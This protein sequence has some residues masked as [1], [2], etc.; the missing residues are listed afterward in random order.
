MKHA[1]FSLVIACV[2][3]FGPFIASADV[4]VR[5]VRFNDVKPATVKLSMTFEGVGLDPQE[6]VYAYLCGTYTDPDC[7]LVRWDPR[8]GKKEYLGSFGAAAKRAGNLGPNRYW[9][10]K[11]FIVKGHTHVWYLDGKMWVGTMNAHD[12]KDMSVIRGGH[13]MAYDLATGIITDHSQWQPKGVFKDR[14]G[15]YAIPVYPPKNVIV[16]IGVPNNSPAGGCELIIYNP[17]TRHAK[18]IPGLPDGNDN[19]QL[20]GRDAAVLPD[21]RVLYQCGPANT[22]F[23]MYNINTGANEATRFRTQSVLTSGVEVTS[24]GSKAYV[25]DLKNIYEFNLQTGTQRTLTT[26]DPR[27]AGGLQASPAVLSLDEKKLYYVINMSYDNGPWIQDLYEYNITSGVR[28]KLMNL[29]RAMGEAKVS[30]SHNTASNGKI[31]FVF[32]TFGGSAGIL[33]VDV[34]GRTGPAPRNR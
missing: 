29:K 23:G 26:L 8:T 15:F 1:F 6:R 34:S 11:E 18:H 21:G 27:G 5:V 30:G 4:P 24:D 31:Y 19:G 20:A 33:E 14:G 13:L 9:P 12:Y 7:H 25:T 16:G 32:S 22:A 17:R 10:K 2:P 3:F 28:T